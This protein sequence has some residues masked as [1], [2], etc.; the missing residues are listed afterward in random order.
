MENKNETTNEKVYFMAKRDFRS[1]Y[2]GVASTFLFTII[3]LYIGIIYK[4]EEYWGIGIF[5]G[6][7]T[8]ALYYFLIKKRPINDNIKITNIGII[9]RLNEENNIVRWEQIKECEVVD[10]GDSETTI[11]KLKITTLESKTIKVPINQYNCAI[12]PLCI[13]INKAH[14]E[15]KNKDIPPIA[16][17]QNAAS[18]NTLEEEEKKYEK[19]LIDTTTPKTS[20][21]FIVLGIII[22][23]IIVCYKIF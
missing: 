23:I 1:R 6:I 13:S 14:H 2:W 7:F 8:V 3:I 4:F 22:Y 5:G 21:I 18:S 16:N 15:F 19:G 20:W 17:A 12:K 10:E 9:W 11:D